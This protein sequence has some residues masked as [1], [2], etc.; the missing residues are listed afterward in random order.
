MRSLASS[1][2]PFE[3]GQ[4]TLR[5]DSLLVDF[6]LGKDVDLPPHQETFWPSCAHPFSRLKQLDGLVNSGLKDAASP[7]RLYDLPVIEESGKETVGK[8]DVGRFVFSFWRYVPR[9]QHTPKRPPI[10]PR[11]TRWS[12]QREEMRV[13]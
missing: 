2:S 8:H 3:S 9:A 11:Y 4:T 5:I 7:N 12:S 13:R 10:H 1:H 6:A